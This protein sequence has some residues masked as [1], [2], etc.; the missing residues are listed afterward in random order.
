MTSPQTR[1]GK[2]R[3]TLAAV[4]TIRPTTSGVAACTNKRDV[5]DVAG[6]G[7]APLVVRIEAASTCA[8][9][10]LADTCGFRIAMPSASS[11][12]RARSRARNRTT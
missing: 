11:R 4:A 2:G 12:A 5:F 6:S 9:C 3:R 1:G 8:T 7:R 10:P